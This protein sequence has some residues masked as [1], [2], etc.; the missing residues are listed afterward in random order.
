MND[1]EQIE[2]IRSKLIDKIEQ[3]STAVGPEH[4][5]VP[6][7]RRILS[8]LPK[9]DM[10]STMGPGSTDPRPSYELA[11][12]PPDPREVFSREKRTPIM[13]PDDPDASR[14]IG[15]ALE[16]ISRLP[17]GAPL[18]EGQGVTGNE[19]MT[20]D[21]L[22]REII[23]GQLLSPVMKT[24]GALLGAGASKFL[25]TRAG[26]LGELA[27]KGTVAPAA[28]EMAAARASASEL[29]ALGPG[30][31]SRGA[32]AVMARPGAL[33]AQALEAKA[34]EAAQ[35]A[36]KFKQPELTWHAITGALAGHHVLGLKGAFYA[37]LLELARQNALPIGARLAPAA[38]R[39]AESNASPLSTA[40]AAA[41]FSAAGNE[42]QR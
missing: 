33:S 11:S 41:A 14:P 30:E 13:G 3:H 35:E 40:A 17:M 1:D 20:G 15:R 7:M 32:K 18:G 31:Y 19:G 27:S 39:F 36:I 25:G 2:R 9:S 16:S 37:A 10:S 42:V 34:V 8:K 23:S 29:R 38:R 22:A 5:D 26:K 21:P 12:P 4:P 28:E 24:A 6:Q